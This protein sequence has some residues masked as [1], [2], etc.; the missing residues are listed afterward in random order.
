VSRLAL[1][2]AP[3]ALAGCALL[4]KGEPVVPR[5]FSPEL[6]G[7]PAAVRAPPGLQ[8]R[9]GQVQ[10]WSHLRERLVVRDSE[11]ERSYR[12]GWRWTERP[13][14]YLRRALARALFE[15]R[16]LVESFSGRAATLEVELM[17]FEELPGPHRVRLQAHYLLRDERLALLSG[18]IT[19]EQAVA[20]GDP[21][22]AAEALT[23]AYA[24]ALQAGV[25]RLVDPVVERL[26][27]TPRDA[28]P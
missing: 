9:L 5:L 1:L 27:S 28:P 13:E 6:E 16:G 2:V 11:H 12:Q 25:A 18:T 15:E 8:L 22:G 3:L 19:E 24:R 14:V 21:G 10:G 23:S 20:P 7:P 26:A 4:G 17:A